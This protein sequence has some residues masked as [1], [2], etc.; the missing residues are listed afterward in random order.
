LEDPTATFTNKVTIR[1]SAEDVFAFLADFENVPAWNH[2]IEETKKTSDGQVGVGTTYRQIRSMPRRSEEG[3]EVT[4]FEPGGRLAVQG[5]VG[6]F[7]SRVSYL[8][9]STEQGTRVTNS[10]DLELHGAFRLGGPLVVSRVRQ[11]V[12]ANLEKL[13]Q[14]LEAG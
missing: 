9:K 2:A 10:V 7:P 13:R 11:A 8:L 1:K 4:D 3:F 14:V 5:R 12:A 6:P